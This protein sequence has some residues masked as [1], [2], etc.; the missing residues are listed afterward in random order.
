MTLPHYVHCQDILLS[1]ALKENPVFGPEAIRRLWEV[2]KRQKKK[3]ETEMNLG[4]LISKPTI[5]SVT[6]STNSQCHP[7]GAHRISNRKTAPREI[8]RRKFGLKRLEPGNT[9]SAGETFE[10]LDAT[11]NALYLAGMLKMP[12]SA[13]GKSTGLDEET[14]Q[15]ILLRLKDASQMKSPKDDAALHAIASFRGSPAAIGDS[16]VGCHPLRPRSS[17]DG[18]RWTSIFAGKLKRYVEFKG[19]PA[20]TTIDYI[21]R[22]MLPNR[23]CVV[24]RDPESNMARK[25]LELCRWL[26]ILQEQIAG[27]SSDGTR[28]I[29]PGEEWLSYWGLSRRWK[30]LIVNQH[31]RRRLLHKPPKWLILEPT[32]FERNQPGG[33]HPRKWLRYALLM[34]Y[35]RFGPPIKL[36]THRPPVLP[37]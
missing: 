4:A 24:F 16:A 22:N 10:W 11:E 1:L 32:S 31:G 21:V 36:E 2:E 27:F 33:D 17:E 30:R 5:Y 15:Q 23:P 25:Y 26:G 20:R 19:E 7:T 18:V 29:S 8:F 6:H 9:E 35:I 14:V 34:A 28:N 12:L 37:G 13:V 3:A